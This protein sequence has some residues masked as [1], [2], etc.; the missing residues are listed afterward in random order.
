M[1]SLPR[2]VLAILAVTMAYRVATSMGPLAI[3][4]TLADKLSLAVASFALTGWTFAGALSQPLWIAIVKNIGWRPTFLLL[5]IVSFASHVGIGIV[6]GPLSAVLVSTIAGASLPPITAQARA[7][8]AGLLD[9][10]RRSVAF[11]AEAA[12]AS[13]AFVI[14]PLVVAASNFVGQLGPTI[15]CAALLGLVSLTFAHVGHGIER[16]SEHPDEGPRRGNTNLNWLTQALIFSGAAAYGMLACIE[17]AV[18]ARIDDRTVAALLLTAWAGAS[19]VGGLMLSR[20]RDIERIR[21]LLLPVPSVASIA[22]AG[23]VTSNLPLFSIILVMSGLAVAPTI[24]FLTSEVSRV[25]QPSQH[26][27][28]YG[29]LQAA[30]W[31]GS[32]IATAVAGSLADISLAL[33][34]LLASSL[35]VASFSLIYLC[36]WLAPA[37]AP[38]TFSDDYG[39]P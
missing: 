11:D 19:L 12:L 28:A 30:S 22:M 15:S 17:V 33:L 10:D 14:A 23:L 24:A 7:L 37:R 5:G 27:K 36:R 31:L 25:T 9:A 13:S 18:V 21:L 35:A 38:L 20:F 26:A 1:A 16:K 2:N 6:S 29:W 8:L 34:L 39:K 3:L 32:A 4:V